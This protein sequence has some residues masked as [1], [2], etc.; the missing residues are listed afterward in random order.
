MST[1]SKGFIG[2]KYQS[3][4]NKSSILLQV[5]KLILE[6]K[7]PV[8]TLRVVYPRGL[9][10]ICLGPWWFGP[11][12]RVGSHCR[13]GLTLASPHDNDW[14]RWLKKPSE[15]AYIYCM[16]DSGRSR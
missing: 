11:R 9:A 8:H 6:P 1:G 10:K 15:P 16:F 5:M 13:A 7:S 2:R 4:F 3:N 12:F 14:L